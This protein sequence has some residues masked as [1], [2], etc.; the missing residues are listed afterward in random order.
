[1]YS[2]AK[3]WRLLAAEAV[4]GGGTLSSL[5]L[6]SGLANGALYALLALAFSLLFR[7]TH[8][9]YFAIGG[10]GTVV[11]L[12]TFEIYT[13]LDLPYAVGCLI[14]MVL[15]GVFGLLAYEVIFRRFNKRQASVDP[16]YQ[17]L[18]YFVAAI[19][20]NTLLYGIAQYFW[21]QGEPYNFPRA[22]PVSNSLFG[23][24][25]SSQHVAIFLALAITL[26]LLYLY[27]FRTYT[28][29]KIRAVAE[30]DTTA[31]A[32]GLNVRSARRQVWALSSS[33]IGLAAML[34]APLL[35]LDTGV[36]NPVMSKALAGAIL[37]GMIS[38][39]GAV[40]GGLVLGVIENLAVPVWANGRDSVALIVIVIMLLV[41]PQGLFGRVQ[42][43][44]L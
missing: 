33:L 2:T 25:V 32:L 43:R 17:V 23:L 10:T 11:A 18:V 39:P 9:P 19:S 22:L 30:N 4:E 6:F 34:F 12:T 31:E 36:L 8:V 24:G 3:H 42:A 40:I 14:S 1:M 29:L 7:T 21:A 37:G 38:L 28:G 26:T 15:G 16:T 20:L 41:R 44:K 27:L 5:L 13:R 35:F